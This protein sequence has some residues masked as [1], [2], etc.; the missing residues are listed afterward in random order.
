MFRPCVFFLQSCDDYRI[1]LFGRELQTRMTPA[2]KA[3]ARILSHTPPGEYGSDFCSGE[4]QLI[5]KNRQP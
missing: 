1:Y 5:Y 3:Q 4:K 2:Q